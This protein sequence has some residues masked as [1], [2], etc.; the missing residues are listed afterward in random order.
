M[1]PDERRMKIHPYQLSHIRVGEITLA[2]YSVAGE[3]AVVVA[4]ELDCAFDIGRCPRE[5]LTV[6]HV[7]LTHGHM[8]HVAGLPYYFA[9]RDFQG[10]AGGV[11]VVPV[12]LVAPIEALLTAWGRVEGHVPPHEV[13]GV[14]D[15]DDYEIRR[16]L[17]ARAFATRHV[18]GSLGFSI[19]DVRAKLKSEYLELSGPQI[20]EL[21]KSGVQITDRLEVPLVAYLG[22][23]GKANYAHLPHVANAQALLIECTFFDEEHLHRARQGKHVHVADLPEMLEGMN[24]AKIILLHLTRRTN[25]AA[26]RRILRRSL[27]KG[28]L[29]RVTFLMSRKEI[30]EE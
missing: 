19:I 1:R 2:G 11:A 12:G 15:G 25:M 4:P 7:L 27:P 9:Q 13:V 14:A 18:A 6:N 24:N 3:E 29:E 26:A 28:V 22:D 23:T 16:G 8:D 17:I 5:A 21:K 20:V 30:E 10:I